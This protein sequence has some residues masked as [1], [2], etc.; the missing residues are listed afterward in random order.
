MAFDFRANELCVISGEDSGLVARLPKRIRE[1]KEDLIV[2]ID[3]THERAFPIKRVL[4]DEDN[5]FSFESE[6]GRR[7]ELRPLTMER[8]EKQIRPKL[9]GDPK[10]KTEADLRQHFLVKTIL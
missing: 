7:F 1:D 8:Y 2:Y 10:L 6:D 5:L 9:I 4:R 3:M